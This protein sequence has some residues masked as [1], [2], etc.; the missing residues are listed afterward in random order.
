LVFGLFWLSCAQAIPDNSDESAQAL[1]PAKAGVILKL[2]ESADFVSLSECIHETSGLGFSP[3]S[4]N[5]SKLFITRFQRDEVA[6]F[7]SDDT[8][9]L[10]GYYDGIGSPIR[11]TPKDYFARFVYDMDFDTKAEKSFLNSNALRKN[12]DFRAVYH[13]YPDSSFVHYHFEGTEEVAFI[14]FRDLILIFSEF[15]GVWYLVG[16]A[17]GQSTI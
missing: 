6:D 2:V 4:R 10:W 7:G 14:D 15:H 1:L 5:L 8:R 9:Y 17:H 12:A 11:L 13:A 16:L 3:Y